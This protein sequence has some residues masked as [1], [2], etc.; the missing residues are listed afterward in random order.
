MIGSSGWWIR[1]VRFFPNREAIGWYLSSLS[2][3]VW[4]IGLSGRRV[5]N[6][7]RCSSPAA[8]RSA[9][10]SSSQCAARPSLYRR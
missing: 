1:S 10:M 6:D 8:T 4:V 5:A 7:L 2:T 9:A 3:P